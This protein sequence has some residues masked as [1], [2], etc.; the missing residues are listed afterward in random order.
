MAA[1]LGVA[2][3]SVSK[4]ATRKARTGSVAPGKM[5][6][7]KPGVLVGEPAV[8]LRERIARADFTLR[9]LMTEL[10]E[11]NVRAPYRAVWRFVHAEKLSYKKKRSAGRAGP[12]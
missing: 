3:S 7:H 1:A 11:R 9:G 8:W 6:G 4:W 5:G 12:C 10:A 2:P